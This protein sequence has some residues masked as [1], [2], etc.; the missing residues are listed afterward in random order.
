V[1]RLSRSFQVIGIDTGRSATYDFLLVII[2][3]MGLP[4]DVFML[5]SDDF[6]ILAVRI[7]NVPRGSFPWSLVTAV[8]SKNRND[9]V[10]DRQK[11]FDDM[12]NHLEAVR[13]TNRRTDLP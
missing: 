5:K 4:R 2:E 3:T 8:G 11:E 10:S 6:N 13:L 12:L 1:R 7:F 9:A